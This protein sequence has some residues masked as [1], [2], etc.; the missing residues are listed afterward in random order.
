MTAT[1][2]QDVEIKTWF[3][4]VVGRICR[5]GAKDGSFGVQFV[6][7]TGQ[8]IREDCWKNGWGKSF[9]IEVAV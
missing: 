2:G 7:D 5:T 6:S 8:T 3:G 4:P 1:V 9:N